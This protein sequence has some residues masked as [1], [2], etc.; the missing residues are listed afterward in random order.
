MEKIDE[1]LNILKSEKIQ[2][3]L[4]Y[5]VLQRKNSTLKLQLRECEGT[6]GKLTSTVS[7]LENKIEALQ[8]YSMKSNLVFHNMP[9]KEGEDCLVEVLTFMQHHLKIPENVLFSSANPFGDIRVDVAHHVGAKSYRPRS[10][11]VKFMSYRGRDLVLSYVKNL[12]QSPYAISEHLLVSVRE[13]RLAQIPL[14]IEKR[15]EAKNNHT[16]S[17]VKMVADKLIVNSNVSTEAFELN[18]LDTTMPASEPIPLETLLYSSPVTV[19]GS[20]FQGHLYPVH[21]EGELIQAIRPIS[22]DKQLA[23]SNHTMY[24]YNFID[25]G[26]VNRCGYFDDG[27]W[28]G[29]SILSSILCEN[30]LSNVV[31]IITMK[32]RG[33]HR[34]KKCFELIRQMANEAIALYSK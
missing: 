1:V 23:K 12:K 13:R 5:N 34:G 10:M 33:V 3:E 15:N 16:N 30:Q 26:G 29:G 2:R 21:T 18:P 14:L 6:I 7:T 28:R 31:I 22:Q 9:E 32:F 24:A 19:K 27:E 17:R 25:P 11:I 8:I 20:I 4:D